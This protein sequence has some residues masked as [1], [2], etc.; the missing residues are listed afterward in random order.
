MPHAS[1]QLIHLGPDEMCNQAGIT[2]RPDNI[3]TKAITTSNSKFQNLPLVNSGQ[4]VPSSIL[5]STKGL[6][7]I[8]METVGSFKRYTINGLC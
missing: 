3:A 4:C 7:D 2:D 1:T 5:Q 8:Q 6:L